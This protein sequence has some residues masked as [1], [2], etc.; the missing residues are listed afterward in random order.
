MR[1]K[2]IGTLPGAQRLRLA[3]GLPLRN[4]PELDALL[5]QLYDPA[6]PIYRHFL[7]PEQFTERFGPTATDYQV[8]ID[9][10]KSNGLAVTVTHPNRV[11]L[12]V[13]GAVSDI[14]RAFHLTLRTYQ[15][16]LEARE[17]YAPDI[18]PSVDLAVPILHLSGLD[19][20]SLP[21]PNLKVRP[22]SVSANATPNAGSAPGGTYRGSDF[23]AAYAP[24]TSLTG[25]GQSVGLLQFDGFYSSDITTYETQAGLSNVPLTVVPVDGGVSKPGNGDIEVS[26]D[27]E[28]AISMAPGITNVYVFEAPNSSGEWDNLLNTM[29][30]YTNVHQF[31]CSWG[32]GSPD[33][34]AEGIFKQMAAQGQSFFNATGDSDAFTGAI[35]FPSDSTNITEVGGT[36]LTTGTSAAYT[37]ETAW[38]WGLDNGSYV[39]TS[40]G[41]STYY[42]IPS[43]Q[44]G[45]SMSANQGSAS[46]RNVPDVAL[47]ADNIYVVYNKG[48]TATVGG[49]SCAAPLWAGF[50][51]LINQQAGQ[52]KVGFLNPALYNIGRG[53][54]YAACFHDTTTG[55]NFSA[56]SPTNF[57]A[58]AGYDLCTGWGT[59]AG[60]NL[61]NALTLPPAVSFTGSPTSGAAPLTVSFT[62]LSTGANNY[63]WA[64][65]DGHTSTN[66]NPANTYSN[67]GTYS[68]ALTA[69]SAGGTST[70]TRTS[71]IVVGAP[72]LSAAG[73]VA[74]YPTNYPSSG[75]SANRVG[76]V[77]MNLTGTLSMNGLTL[78]DG[79][80]NLSNISTG[81]TYCVTPSM[82][83]D[84]P[85]LNGVSS[86]D[87]ALIQA[88]ILG[89]H[90]L[91]S[92]YKLLAADVNGD[93]VINSADQVYIQG[94]ILG[95]INQFPAGLW[96]FVPS[97]YAFPNPQAPWT[98]PANR[99]YTN[100]VADV[101]N[102]NFVAIKLGDVAN[103]WTAPSGQM[104]LLAK[105]VDGPLAQEKS[106]VPAVVFAVSQQ[107]APAGETVTVGVV[108]RGFRQ[109]TSAQFSL[110]WNPA[111][112]RYVGTGSYGLTRLSAGSFGTTL[113]KS[114]RL[115]FAWYDPEAVGVTLAD[116]TVLF[117]V[118][119]EAV[120]RTGSVSAVALANSPIAQELSMDF[121]RVAFGAQ[122]GSVALVGTGALV[123]NAS[124]ATGIFRL[125]VP[126]VP[127][128]SY[129][130]EFTDGLAPA[131]WMALPAVAGHGTVSVLI[132][133]AATN[134][135]RFYRVRVE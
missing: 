30:T 118:S 134:Q 51:A 26:L 67:A 110:A 84:S 1:L 17:F 104:N 3:I 7:T 101:T 135:Q 122:D 103:L 131:R 87:Q 9:F 4:Q 88:H 57:A 63:N 19:N 42:S 81:G 132:D 16:P 8:L 14:Q 56:S 123:S 117:N 15:H 47:T 37:S 105:T 49:T 85:T 65:G 40:G 112:L 44:Q 128:R 100:V 68:V 50:T 109:V 90:L 31:S 94:L 6:S 53:A 79:S 77:T 97:D 73:T 62:N 2:P 129:T 80:Y 22:A 121:A 82:T 59:P 25:A 115:A 52:T 12:G 36:T 46:M 24:G 113:A 45:I 119:F 102:G 41:I 21:H 54:S 93:G 34:T 116:G 58:V 95:R 13:A 89:L 106:A 114:G 72:V 60:T 96:R 18:E 130:L 29:V 28:M 133:P 35:P 107:T 126:T 61:I 99:W 10:A 86:A 69:I 32:G 55:N 5:Q 43:Y 76:N 66:V 38:N 78:S 27:I 92:P 39:G 91:D 74:Y 70:L 33:A 108:V 120:G 127:G 48:K 125:S 124:H 83:T 98:A 111:V 71:Y 75:L 20:Y 11:V 23:R 64:F